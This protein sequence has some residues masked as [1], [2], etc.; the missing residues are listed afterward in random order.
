MASTAAGWGW[1]A[2]AEG[3]AAVGVEK[4]VVGWEARGWAEQAG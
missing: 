1:A 3:M 2:A 4:E